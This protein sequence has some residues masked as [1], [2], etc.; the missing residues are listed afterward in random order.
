MLAFKLPI[1]LPTT[2]TDDTRIRM[3]NRLY[4]KKRK[5][6]QARKEA[7]AAA[8]AAVAAAA[9]ASGGCAPP[10]ELLHV[11]DDR[12]IDELLSFIEEADRCG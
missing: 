3:L 8:A 2:S 7:A 9:A 5:E 1:M 10:A 6:L 11:Q 12:P 4:A